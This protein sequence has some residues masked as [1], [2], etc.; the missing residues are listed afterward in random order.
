MIFLNL[1]RSLSLSVSVRTFVP[2][3]GFFIDAGVCFSW[4]R[5]HIYEVENAHI[6]DL[7]SVEVHLLFVSFD[8]DVAFAAPE[9]LLKYNFETW[10][11]SV[12]CCVMWNVCSFDFFSVILL[13][14]IRTQCWHNIS[15][16]RLFLRNSIECELNSGGKLTSRF[17][18]WPLFFSSFR[19]NRVFA[20]TFHITKFRWN[21]HWFFVYERMRSCACVWVW[22]LVL[23]LD[24]E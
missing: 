17:T 1:A 7:Y 8:F 3:V 15:S 18:V 23:V 21:S 11:F 24:L 9:S 20:R 16:P 4:R 13:W 19:N 6:S 12:W 5:P 14:K 2:V 22:A 10:N